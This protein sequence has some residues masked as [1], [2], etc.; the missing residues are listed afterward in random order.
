[1]LPG[2]HAPG[3]M[4]SPAPQAKADITV[5]CDDEV[6][7]GLDHLCPVVSSTFWLLAVPALLARTL[8]M[9]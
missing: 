5:I 6:L 3:C 9:L 7:G 8:S 1:M 4:L 2:A